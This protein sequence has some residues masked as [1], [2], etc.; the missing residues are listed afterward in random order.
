MRQILR[1][2]VILIVGALGAGA[3]N[4]QQTPPKPAEAAPAVESLPT[5]DQ[6]LA[7]YVDALGGKAAM[8]K[9]TS[10]LAKGTFEIPAMG[11]AGD[12][13]NY[14]KAPNKTILTFTLPGFGAFQQ[15][16]DG[17]VAWAQDPTSG[18][19]EL[20]GV[21]LA[22][23]KLDADFYREIRRKELYPTLKVRGKEKV[24][25]RTAYVI[26]ATPAEGAT[27]TWYFD[28]ETGLLLR[29]DVERETPQGKI[30]TETAYE[31]YR[32]VGGFKM[33]MTI[34]Q[35]TPIF[36][37]TVRITEVRLNVEIDDAKFRKPVAQS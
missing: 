3:Q 35:S 19:R 14:A 9:V 6:I 27:E 23:V 4:P 21:E 15:G 17:T 26:E 7:A 31:D 13:E 33:P 29:T 20:T 36:T 22:A 12:F 11:A 18:L 30:P 24:G 2:G 34:R 1:I 5:A 28:A 32:D 37:L 25:D 10:R 8:E 16:F